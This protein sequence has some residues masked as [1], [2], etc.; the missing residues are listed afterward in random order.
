MSVHEERPVTAPRLDPRDA[1][2]ALFETVLAMLAGF[3]ARHGALLS[4]LSIPAFLAVVLVIDWLRPVHAWDTIAYLGVV[5]RDWMGMTAP[6]DIHAYAYDTVRKAVDPE[7]YA[8]LTQI[9]AYRERMAADPKAFVSMLGMYEV[10]WLYVALLAALGPVFGAYQAG[11]AINAGAAVILSAGLIW[12]LRAARMSNLGVIV[13]ALMMVGGTASIAMA[14]I[15]DFLAFAL[16][17]TGV[18]MLDRDRVVGGLALLFVSVLLRPDLIAFSGVLMAVAWFWRD[19]MTSRTALAFAAAF[20]AYVVISRSGTH[21]GWWA[22]A[23]FSIYRMENTL[24]GFHPHFSL[25]IYLTGF[26]WNL[27]R[28]ALENTW[29][30]L[31]AL[32]LVGWAVMQGAG[33]RMVP[34]RAA[35]VAALLTGVAAKYTVFPIHDTR[36]YIALLFP[37]ILL[38]AAGLRDGLEREATDNRELAQ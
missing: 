28:S 8:I 26:A 27:V 6:A 20:V 18:L 16:T 1:L 14:D 11:F 35:L 22:H 7:Q 33:V 25:A 5:A 21:P 34:R 15:P 12:W 23:Q 31:Y 24:E 13:P 3:W 36:F 37:A 4:A 32:A 38:L 17:V 2:R 9:D 10:K 19:R 30:G 29:L